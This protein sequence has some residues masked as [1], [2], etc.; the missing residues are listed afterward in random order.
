MTSAQ[1]G[2]FGAGGVRYHRRMQS[3]PTPPFQVQELVRRGSGPY[4]Y[5]PK[6]ESHLEARLW[7]DVF[8]R[9]QQE[10]GIPAGTP[11]GREM[12]G[13]FERATQP[14]LER[15]DLIRD[16]SLAIVS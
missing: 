3:A 9:A 4:F 7:N 14:L 1:P 10:L 11:V 8:V 6:M 13:P 16:A 12:R 15:L 5:L 2:W